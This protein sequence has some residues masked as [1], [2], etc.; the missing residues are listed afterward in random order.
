MKKFHCGQIMAAT[1]LRIVVRKSGGTSNLR[2]AQDLDP[3]FAARCFQPR[4]ATLD[5]RRSSVN[6]GRTGNR[7]Q[8][9]PGRSIE[10]Y[11]GVPVVNVLRG[12]HVACGSD[13]S[14]QL[15]IPSGPSQ[16]P[17]LS[18]SIFSLP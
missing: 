17:P 9:T 10:H 8:L 16:R 18:E 7:P 6:G 5:I 12:E 3:A 15:H 11:A 13:L 2:S 14:F 1:A 4:V